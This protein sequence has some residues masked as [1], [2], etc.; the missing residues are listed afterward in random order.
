M[1]TYVQ[2]TK[3]LA[4]A[5]LLAVAIAIG[6]AIVPQG[7]AQADEGNLQAG[8]VAG[9]TL[10]TQAT[11]EA[12]VYNED[13]VNFIKADGSGF[14]MYTAQ[15]GTEAILEN[16]K[17]LI[18]YYPKN[19]TTYTGLYINT[20]NSDDPKSD[21]NYHA[22]VDGK[23][24]LELDVSNCG[25]A[26]PV[27]IVKA[28]KTTTPTAQYYLAIP[29]ADKLTTK[30]SLSPINDEKM[31]K[32]VKAT[33]EDSVGGQDY[34][35]FY[36]SGKSY[37]WAFSGNQDDAVS[38]FDGKE[39]NPSWASRS[40][41]TTFDEEATYTTAYDGKTD[42]KAAKGYGF[43]IPIT[44]PDGQSTFSLDLVAYA[45]DFTARTF[46]IDLGAMTLKTGTASDTATV[47]VASELEDIAAAASG[48][49]EYTGYARPHAGGSLSTDTKPLSNDWVSTLTINIGDNKTYDQAYVVTYQGEPW[50]SADA[51]ANKPASGD[52][53][54]VASDGSLVLAIAN[55]YDTNPRTV[56][57]DG[58]IVKVM[59][60]VASNAP[61]VDAGKWVE[62]TF[63]IDFKSR[64]AATLTISGD[65][66]LTK[67]ADATAK[68]IAALPA[69]EKVNVGSKATIEAA[70]ALYDKLSDAQKK[71][72]DVSALEAAEAAL[73]KALDLANGTVTVGSMT[74]TGSALTPAVT[75]KDASGAALT[76]N[77][78]Y[79]V[80]YSNN[81]NAGKATVTVKGKGDYTGSKSANFTIAKANAAVTASDASKTFG[82]AAFS[83]A[84][85]VTKGDGKLTFK[86]SNEKV[87]KVDTNGKVTIVGA[88]SATIT[89]SAAAT[90][91]YNAA[92]A[93]A[94]VKVAKAKS[95]I[96][97]AAQTK[98]FNRKAQ[99]YSGKVTKSGSAGAV[100]YKYYSDKACTKEVKA[101]SVKNAGTYYVKATVAADANH[102]TATSAAAKFTIGKKAN[103]LKVK[104]V[105][106]TQAAKAKKNTTIAAKKA[107]KV[108]KNVSKGKLT[109]KKANKVGGKKI[110]VSKAGKI[111]V[112]KG[113]KNGVYKV[114][115]KVTSKATKNY[116]AKTVTM[117]LKIKVK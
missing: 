105:K 93:T 74:Y 115:V 47:S 112:K 31:F 23:Y 37:M 87:A 75:V 41:E 73:A 21:D 81:I 22:I 92:S 33:L 6:L 100:T 116:K 9:A 96:S 68:A 42:N 86:S 51:V 50:L 82:D 63:T 99:A 36:L 109:Y 39:T 76:A 57:L 94:T 107:F 83:L 2:R 38:T 89:A 72:V 34:L 29:S 67:D 46:T 65:P 8:S 13:T 108:T 26:I 91:N 54:N 55:E 78:H 117:T 84:A 113:L 25:K 79:T 111:T 66:L 11:P 52:Y 32:V 80:S 18:T 97:L 19:T 15:D 104:L 56:Q 44:I 59:M 102:E 61:Y 64:T 16:G 69:A 10:S 98:T 95:S 114:K 30:S 71:L 53:A 77:T 106:K 103:T 7:V 27:A 1:S 24:T 3:A 110:T 48:S 85:K 5:A 35:S 88:G 62:R 14:G 28:D 20:G 12:F 43:R 60:H 45:S 58:N 4:A 40:D 90:A 101:A 70:R 49:F 17:V